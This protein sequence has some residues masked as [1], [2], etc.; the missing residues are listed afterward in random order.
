MG[1]MIYASFDTPNRMAITRWAIH[2]YNQQRYPAEDGIIAELAS[3]NLEFT[4]LSQLT[5]DMRYYDAIARITNL[6]DNQH[7]HN[8]R[9]QIS[10]PTRS[11]RMRT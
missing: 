11:N 3:A 1:D 8:W 4:R 2:D 5:G 6:L 7:N 9:R 10:S